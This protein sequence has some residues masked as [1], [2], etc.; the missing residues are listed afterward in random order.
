MTICNY[1]S[2][3]SHPSFCEKSWKVSPPWIQLPEACAR[4]GLLFAIFLARGP[5]H[6][7]DFK[8]GGRSG[9][10]FFRQI[11]GVKGFLIG[12]KMS[13]VWY[14]LIYFV[15]LLITA[16]CKKNITL[17]FLRSNQLLC[18]GVFHHQS[19]I[20]FTWVSSKQRLNPLYDLSRWFKI[21]YIY[22]HDYTENIWKSMKHF[23]KF[24]RSVFE[25]CQLCF[26][27]LDRRNGD[28]DSCDSSVWDRTF[29]IL[30]VF[31]ALYRSQGRD[32]SNVWED[33]PVGCS[34]KYNFFTVPVI[35]A[36]P[37]LCFVREHLKM[38]SM[39]AACRHFLEYP[40]TTPRWSCILI[41]R[42]GSRVRV[43]KPW[44]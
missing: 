5:L 7:D 44:L 24:E 35:A 41:Q 38:D 17:F 20:V 29:R 39:T 2:I 19:A 21:T 43:R 4:F 9:H 18:I 37:K 12:L 16:D 11:A 15:H 42:F 22:I 31:G 30:Q 36:R 28:C 33:V 23:S 1:I 3:F 26:G 10:Q 34:T 14:S 25:S 32:H 13:Q 27:L 6:G 40:E 8:C